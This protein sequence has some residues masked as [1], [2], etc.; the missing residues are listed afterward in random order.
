MCPPHREC[1]RTPGARS[2]CAPAT[3]RATLAHRYGTVDGNREKSS[4]GK[5]R[6]QVVPPHYQI[7]PPAFRL[8]VKTPRSAPGDNSSEASCP[9]A[10]WGKKVKRIA[11]RPTN[12]G[13]DRW[14]REQWARDRKSVV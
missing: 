5:P 3:R 7:I 1:C 9:P 11:T 13:L 4:A 8:P 10:P 14:N 12:A 6:P 2:P